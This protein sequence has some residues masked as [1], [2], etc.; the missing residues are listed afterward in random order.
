[1]QSPR[2]GKEKQIDYHKSLTKTS[3]EDGE[4]D[5]NQ[6]HANLKLQNL[7]KEIQQAML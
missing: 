2:E 1:M 5:K 7:K 3:K 4:H 6:K